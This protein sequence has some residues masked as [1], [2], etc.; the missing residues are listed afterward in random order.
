MSRVL[1]DVVCFRRVNGPNPPEDE[2]NLAKLGYRQE[3]KRSWGF[4]LNMGT[5]L[6]YIGIISSIATLYS[7]AFKTGGPQT[8]LIGW[9]I[10]AFFSMSTCLSMAEICSAYPTA[11]GL[12]YWSAKLAGPKWGPYMAWITGW[13]NVLG[14]LTGSPAT[15][16]QVASILGSII[17]IYNPDFSPS[18]GWLYGVAIAYAFIGSATNSIGEASLRAFT[19]IALVGIS[20]GVVVIGVPLL[21]MSPSKASASFAFGTFVDLTGWD[22]SAIVFQLGFLLPMWCFWGYDASAHISEETV[23]ADTTPAKSIIYSLVLSI[24]LGWIFL[25][26][27]SFVITDIDE[28]LDCPYNEDLV[29]VY[30]QGTGGSKPMAFFLT[31]WTLFQFV[32]QNITGHNG[33]SRGIYAWARDGGIPQ[34]FAY[35]HPTSKQPLKTIWLHFFTTATLLLINF[36]SSQ[37]VSSF[38][39]FSTIGMYAAYTLPTICKLIW[40]RDT[41][42]R[43][44]INLGSFSTIINLVAALWLVYMIVILSIPRRI[45]VTS[46]NLNLSPIMFVGVFLIINVIWF[47]GARKTFIGPRQHITAEE[48][49]V[50]EKSKE[51]L[52]EKEVVEA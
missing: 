52:A 48:I 4:F 40:A 11:G 43:S 24:A 39:A 8:I 50:L 36:G 14:M 46:S 47:L 23:N 25:L 9:L 27:L 32:F 21:V 29:C 35:V 45:P 44:K 12:Y 17:Q 34:W 1:S 49:E 20:T 6:G 16:L 7:F 51:S 37:A 15:S 28:I 13:F 30:L 10:V 38:S 31:L 33:A 18:L 2:I 3:L 5:S 22:N 42:K 26:I 19:W 41:F